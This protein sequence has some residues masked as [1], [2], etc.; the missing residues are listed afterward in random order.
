MKK[1]VL[2][3]MMGLS[4]AANAA[5]QGDYME[6]LRYDQ[7]IPEHCRNLDVAN[8]EADDIEY[9]TYSIRGAEAKGFTHEYPMSRDDA[10]QLWGAMKSY[11]AGNQNKPNFSNAALYSHYEKLVQHHKAMDFDFHSE[12]EILELLAILELRKTLSPEYYVTGSLAYQDKTAGELD[13]I[14]GQVSNCKVK[15]VGEAKL[16]TGRLGYAQ[17]QLQRFRD[18]ILTHAEF[19]PR[20]IFKTFFPE[21]NF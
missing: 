20:P 14:I 1:F 6:P 11:V 9:I 4:F 5:S 10:R 21:L 8:F 17:K 15:V 7:S 16:N 13:I 12:G 2:A 19:D 3:T 18:F